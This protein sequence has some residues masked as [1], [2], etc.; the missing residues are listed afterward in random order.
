MSQTAARGSEPEYAALVDEAVAAAR[1]AMSKAG[2]PSADDVSLAIDHLSVNLGKKI[3]QI[4]PGYVSTEVDIR[5]SFDAKASEVKG[6]AE[7][8]SEA[9]KS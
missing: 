9:F 8:V 4:V 3:L 2:R 7:F 1:K 6:H 5:L